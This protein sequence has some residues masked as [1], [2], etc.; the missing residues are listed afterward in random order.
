MTRRTLFVGSWKS[1]KTRDEAAQF[2]AQL[3]SVAA[4]FNHEVVLCPAFVHM[5]AAQA[6]PVTVKLGAQNVS[7]NGSGPFTGEI[8]ASMLKSYNVQY[9]IIG[10]VERRAA[11]ETNAQINAKI[12]QLLASGIKPIVCFGETL[13]DYDSNMTRAVIEKQMTECLAGIREWQNLILCYMPIW[14]IGTGYYTSGEYTNIILEFMR[15]TIQ[16]ISGQPMAGNI[17]MLYGGMITHSNARE[18]LECTQVDGIVFAVAAANPVEFAKMVTT[19][20][21][22]G[23]R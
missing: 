6:L 1:T 7:Q 12:K 5:E 17:P 21:K 19:Q 20:F 18:Y 2:F 14:S 4:N 15:K 13:A 23:V 3:P 11:G 9:C 10:H 16:K 8:S 22:P